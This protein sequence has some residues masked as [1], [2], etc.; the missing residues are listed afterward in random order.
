VT[1][2]GLCRA[3]LAFLFAAL[4]VA[5]LVEALSLPLWVESA[6]TLCAGGIAAGPT[7]RG[8]GEEAF[9]RVPPRS[10]GVDDLVGLCSR[11]RQIDESA[12]LIFTV[13]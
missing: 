13:T 5:F 12:G 3:A 8:Q 7:I 4:P 10:P 2:S 11:I 9:R 6:D 1:K